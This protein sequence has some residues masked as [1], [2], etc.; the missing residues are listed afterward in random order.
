MTY[1]DVY[2]AISHNYT[3][4]KQESKN[5]YRICTIE[6]LLLKLHSLPRVAY[7]NPNHSLVIFYIVFDG[8]FLIQRHR[9]LIIQ[10]VVLTNKKIS[11]FFKRE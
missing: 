5:R 8:F 6:T 4:G 9:Q 11:L 1:N 3:Y 10:L 2:L 7:N